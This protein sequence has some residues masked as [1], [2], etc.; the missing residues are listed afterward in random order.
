VSRP[1]IPLGADVHVFHNGA[2]ASSRNVSGSLTAVYVPF[3][4]NGNVGPF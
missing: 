1:P 4:G 3:D 2:G